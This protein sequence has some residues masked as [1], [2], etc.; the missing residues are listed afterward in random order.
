MVQ[1]SLPKSLLR[2]HF[3]KSPLNKEAGGT[4][5]H[6]SCGDFLFRSSDA[7]SKSESDAKQPSSASS[8]SVVRR[9]LRL[10]FACAL[11]AACVVKNLTVGVSSQPVVDGSYI[12]VQ[13]RFPR[14]AFTGTM[15]QV[16]AEVQKASKETRSTGT[17][18]GLPTILR[19]SLEDSYFERKVFGK[20]L[21]D[22]SASSSLYKDDSTKRT[23]YRTGQPDLHEKSIFRSRTCPEK[24]MCS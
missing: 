12:D 2:L 13:T 5:G 15:A 19:F 14:P 23:K 24:S 9:F 16:G 22:S 20:G 7:A 18:S 10:C 17:Y 11:A 21:P 4:N 1:P 6:L 8:R 3:G